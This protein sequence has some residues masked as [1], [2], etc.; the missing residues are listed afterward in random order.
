MLD[1]CIWMWFDETGLV[2]IVSTHIDDLN[3]CGTSS[4]Q[5]WRYKELVTAFGK[6]KV[7]HTKFEHCGIMHVQHEN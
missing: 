2:G 7:E 6:V 3:G 5:D 1:S 4:W